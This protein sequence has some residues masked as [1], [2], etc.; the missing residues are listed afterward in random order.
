MIDTKFYPPRSSR[1]YLIWDP[2]QGTGQVELKRTTENPKPYPFLE[3]IKL[4]HL[5]IRNCEAV[6]EGDVHGQ[7]GQ[8][9]QWIGSNGQLQ[10]VLLLSGDQVDRLNLPDADHGAGGCWI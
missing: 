9:L 3:T 5:D 7:A 2:Q 4:T 10:V 1:D 8:G 6:G